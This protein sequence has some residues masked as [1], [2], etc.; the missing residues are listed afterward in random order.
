MAPKNPSFVATRLQC[1]QLW[2][3]PLPRTRKIRAL[4]ARRKSVPVLLQ[5][6]HPGREADTDMLEPV[7]LCHDPPGS[8]RSPAGAFFRSGPHEYHVK[9]PS[10]QISTTP[11]LLD[12]I[13]SS[14][15]W[16]LVS[17]SYPV[18]LIP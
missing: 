13:L 9:R 4:N 18:I 12:F 11:V 16:I 5:M 1:K 8:F 15:E 6:T 10:Q 2:S 3:V 7:L 14:E 17:P